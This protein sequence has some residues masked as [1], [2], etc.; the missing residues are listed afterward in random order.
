MIA[1]PVSQETNFERAEPHRR[2]VGRVGQEVRA[3]VDMLGHDREDLLVEEVERR[4]QRLLELEDE[5]SSIRR[6]RIGDERHQLGQV[7]IVLA[8]I[9][10]GEHHIGRA[11][12]L[13]VRPFDAASQLERVGQPIRRDLPGLGEARHALSVAVIG[14]QAVSPDI[15]HDQRGRQRGELRVEAGDRAGVDCGHDGPTGSRVVV[16]GRSARERFAGDDCGHA[17]GA[18]ASKETL[19]QSLR[20][21]RPELGLAP[22]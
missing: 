11:E 9:H 5:G 7:S 18:R 13:P 17:E 4:R 14:H 10:Q 22:H 8:E 6:L 19:A 20:P 12:R 3:L 15:C 2:P 16:C 21:A 1:R